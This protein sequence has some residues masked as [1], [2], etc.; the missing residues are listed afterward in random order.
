M[1][2]M[3]IGLDSY[4]GD[5]INIRVKQPSS[6]YLFAKLTIACVLP[7]PRMPIK[8][9]NECNGNNSCGASGVL[10][11]LCF[12]G[13]FNNPFGIEIS[14]IFLLRIGIVSESSSESVIPLILKK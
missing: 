7:D 12:T 14:L 1:Q 10:I 2:C 3:K 5:I 9:H 11:F 4:V 8:A 6:K 13:P